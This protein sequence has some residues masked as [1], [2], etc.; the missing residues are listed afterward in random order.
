M[1]AVAGSTFVAPDAGVRASTLGAAGGG[2]PKAIS[3]S[4]K[5]AVEFHEDTGSPPLLPYMKRPLSTAIPVMSPD[6]RLCAKYPLVYE[7]LPAGEKYETTYVTPG[8]SVTGVLSGAR[9]HPPAVSLHRG[10]A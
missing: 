5:Y 2:V 8:C 10:G 3:A 7:Y 4:T 6:V 1:R 9:C